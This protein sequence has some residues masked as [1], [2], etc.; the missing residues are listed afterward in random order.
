MKSTPFVDN[1]VGCITLG[2]HTVVVALGDLG[3]DTW[4][5]GNAV[6]AQLRTSGFDLAALDS[7]R[8]RTIDVDAVRFHPTDW[9]AHSRRIRLL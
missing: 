4:I 6:V 9:N 5:Y 7:L 2:E 8:D 1:H 3:A